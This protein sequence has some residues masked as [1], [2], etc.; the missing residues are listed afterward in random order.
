VAYILLLK[1]IISMKL[2]THHGHFSSDSGTK[3][4]QCSIKP[5][6]GQSH[7]QLNNQPQ[8]GT[9]IM[10]AKSAAK[11]IIINGRQNWIRVFIGKAFSHYF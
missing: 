4:L 2:F 3:A 9:M 6:H 11:Q 1:M 10:K 7:P 5:R 8:I